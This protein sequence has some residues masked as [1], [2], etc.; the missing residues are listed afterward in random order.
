[1]QH[2]ESPVAFDQ[3]HADTYDQRFAKLASMRDALHLLLSALLTDLPAQARILCVGAGT[4]TSSFICR[5]VSGIAIC[6]GGAF[7]TD[8]GRLSPQSQG[9]RPH[10]PLPL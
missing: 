7:G 8:D 3:A 9:A 4:A 5:E 1:M 6:S 2:Q 10:A